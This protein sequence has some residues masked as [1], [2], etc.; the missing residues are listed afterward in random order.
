MTLE[1]ILASIDRDKSTAFIS[2][3][4]LVTLGIRIKETN[5][6]KEDG[7]FHLYSA[8]DIKTFKMVTEKE[9]KRIRER[10]QIPRSS[11]IL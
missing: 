10:L 3:Q 5:T 2:S 11:I 4:K 6:I 9:V 8:I 7:Y 1:Q